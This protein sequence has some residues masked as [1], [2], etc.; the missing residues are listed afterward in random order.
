MGE[1]AALVEG[2]PPA[3][4][5]YLRVQACLLAMPGYGERGLPARVKVGLALVLTPLFLPGSV[6]LGLA[7]GP[8]LVFAAMLELALGLVMGLQL[9]LM[10]VTLSIA[11]STIAATASLS[12]LFGGETEMTPHPIGNLLHLAGLALLMALGLPALLAAYLA[13]SFEV[14]PA[15]GLPPPGRLVPALVELVARGFGLA[16]VLASPFILG[17]LLYQG[18]TA[19]VGKV[20][21]TLPVVFVG[22]PAAILLALA[23]LA[24]FAPAILGVWA[25]A[26]LGIDLEPLRP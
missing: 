23:G 21:P 22:A 17:G 24:L 3:L 5:V 19:V 6:G 10:A 18:I 9:R 7:T 2:L 13:A 12:Q 1:F 11:A 25:D 26:V 20:M 4:L 15:A 16:M 8:A 14:W